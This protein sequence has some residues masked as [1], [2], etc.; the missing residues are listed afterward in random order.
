[1]K[2][3]PFDYVAARSV[4]HALELLNAGPD[5]RVLAGGQ[6][7]MPLLNLRLASP[8][9]VVD[10]GRIPELQSITVDDG[11]LVIGAGVT[12]AD[13]A[14]DRR[15][16]E[17]WPAL[18][19]AIGHIGHAQIRNRGT[20]CGSLAHNDPLAELPA[21]AV[22]LEATVVVA[23]PTGERTV[24][25]AEVFV[26]PF[27]TSLDAGE[28][29]A[30]V[31][32]PTLPAGTGWSVCELATRPGDFATAG[33]VT[34]LS[35]VDGAVAEARVVLFGLGPGPQ[36]ATLVEEAVIGSTGPGFDDD[37]LARLDASLEPADDAHASSAT[38]RE[39]AA[40]LVTRSLV[41]AW[42]RSR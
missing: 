12:Q 17:G 28:L 23:S 41:E 34:R 15:V 33:V 35:V 9:L 40:V 32:F 3:P 20:V 8:E 29:V 7:L 18:A 13:A 30:A 6:S 25:A 39:L 16:R 37:V 1:V 22:A 36:R 21:V 4:E 10:I 2:P 31:R 27:M 42:E 11:T 24:P 14:A 26:G 5:A 38:R 19:A